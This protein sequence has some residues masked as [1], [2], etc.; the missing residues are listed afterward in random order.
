MCKIPLWNF[1]VKQKKYRNEKYEISIENMA[2][3]F[4]LE[5]GAQKMENYE[6]SDRAKNEHDNNSNAIN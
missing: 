1:A 4:S 6:K 2:R 5:R 3:V